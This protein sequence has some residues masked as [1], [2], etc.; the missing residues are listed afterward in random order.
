[1]DWDRG[2]R[3]SRRALGHSRALRDLSMTLFKR[4][5]EILKPDVIVLTTGASYDGA[6]KS[7]L[8]VAN[9]QDH[10]PNALSTFTAA[11]ANCVRVRH[12]SAIPSKNF[13]VPTAEYYEHIARWIEALRTQPR[14]LRRPPQPGWFTSSET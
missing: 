9:W 2:N 12:P 3:N 6:L 7:C 1:M 4:E 10:V 11:E 8:P 14:E 5:V 13:P